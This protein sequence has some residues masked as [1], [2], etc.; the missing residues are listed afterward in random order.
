MS[1]RTQTFARWLDR[2]QYLTGTV[3]MADATNLAVATQAFSA[4]MRE[5]WEAYW[6]PW[7]CACESRTITAGLIL[8]AQSGQTR[9]AEVISVTDED[10]FGSAG[11][12]FLSYELAP[13]GIKFGGSDIPASAYVYYRK[14]CP[15]YRGAEYNGAT[16]YVAGDQVYYATTG[17]FYVNILASTG[18]APTNTTNWTRLTIPWDLFEYA[19]YQAA[20][21]LLTTNGQNGGSG[22]ASTLYGQ[23]ADKLSNAIEKYS[24][25]QS[26][27]P[28]RQVIFTHGTQQLR[29]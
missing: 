3:S 11:Y 17:D 16:A 8:Y 15:E 24:R 10:P 21:D 14:D 12:T 5:A 22:R 13:T 26:F 20:G 29:N 25:Q 1:D 28:R 2:Y 4:A 6:W 18:T 9:I 27:R 19:A 23:A 7:A